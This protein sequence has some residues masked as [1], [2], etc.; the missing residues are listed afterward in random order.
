[1]IA[2]IV[3]LIGVFGYLITCKICDYLREKNK[4]KGEDE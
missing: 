2:V 1:M 4:K 3:L